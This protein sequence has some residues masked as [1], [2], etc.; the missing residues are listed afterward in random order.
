MGRSETRSGSAAG[1]PSRLARR[2]S[3]AL[4]PRCDDQDHL[5]VLLQLPPGQAARVRA[6]LIGLL[7]P[8]TISHLG[9]SDARWTMTRR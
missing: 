9:S 4:V 8:G 5:V 3:Q 7:G 1:V 6:R 2:W